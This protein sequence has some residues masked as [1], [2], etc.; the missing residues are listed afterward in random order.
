MIPIRDENPTRR[1]PYITVLLIAVNCL[2]FVYEMMLPQGQIEGF[3]RQFGAVPALVMSSTP[4]DWVTLITS[5]FLHGGLLHLLGNMLYLWIFGNNIEDRLGHIG[6]IGF[7]LVGGIAAAM[8]HILIQPDSM[9]P[10]VGASGAIS[11]VLGAYMIIFPRARVVLLIWFIIFVRTIRVPAFLVLGLW[12]VMQLS[13]ILQTSS[14]GIA[15]YAHVGGFVAGIILILA[16]G[17]FRN[18][19]PRWF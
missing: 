2:V 8:T 10:M 13:G 7:Y 14:E 12:F 4:L 11:A 1:T 9:I 17:K 15:W 18:K 6:F 16:S 5:M 3:I 19:K